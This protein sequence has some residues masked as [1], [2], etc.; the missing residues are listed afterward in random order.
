MPVSALPHSSDAVDAVETILEYPDNRLLVD[1]CGEYDRNLAQIEHSLSLQILRR[2]NQ[3]ALM[4]EEASRRRGAEVLDGL[5][6]R[7][8][9]GQV[10]EPGDIDGALRMRM[11]LPQGPEQMEMFGGGALEIETRKKVIRPRTD[12]QKAY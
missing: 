12:A 4:G 2:G 11:T 7:L 5:Y 10:L 1:L 9:K 8:E 6:E 3:L